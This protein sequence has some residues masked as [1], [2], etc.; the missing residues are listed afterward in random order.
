MMNKLLATLFVSALAVPAHAQVSGGTSGGGMMLSQR[1]M[2]SYQSAN[3]D[4]AGTRSDWIQ[5]V[6]LWR[7]QPG[8]ESDVGVNAAQRDA[9]KRMFD[10]ARIAALTADHGFLGGGGG[11]P[12]WAEID[13]QNRKISVLGREFDLPAR[14]SA[15]V[16]LVDRLDGIGGPTTVIGSAVVDGQLGPEVRTKTWR[17][18]DTTFTVSPSKSGIDVFL[19]TLK[20]DPLIAAF[21][22]DGGTR[23]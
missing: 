18:G 1:V 17:S 22:S 14:G 7:G 4:S 8:W 12:Y 16:V 3:L 10:Q 9:A 20:E 19:E 11:H 21:L 2:V 13:R 15:L 23:D 6:I 5:F